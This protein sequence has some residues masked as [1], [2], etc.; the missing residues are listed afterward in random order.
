MEVVEDLATGTDPL[1]DWRILYLNYLVH[2]ALPAY[3]TEVRRLA[4]RAKSFILVDR[5][6]YKRSP[7]R[8]L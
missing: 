8:I 6:L 1:P 3:K 5:E 2:G 4:R 7:T